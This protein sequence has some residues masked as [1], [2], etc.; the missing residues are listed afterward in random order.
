MSD[1]HAVTKTQSLL[2]RKHTD[3]TKLC[4]FRRIGYTSY[5]AKKNQNSV[6]N[7]KKIRERL[8][9]PQWNRI[10][11]THTFQ[12]YKHIVLGKNIFDT[13]PLFYS[14][15]Y[16]TIQKFLKAAYMKYIFHQLQLIL[17]SYVYYICTISYWSCPNL[18]Y[19]GSE[20]RMVSD[21]L[22]P[23]TQT[24]LLQDIHPMQVLIQL[25]TLHSKKNNQMFSSKLIQSS[26]W[27]CVLCSLP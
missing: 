26:L 25:P 3:K 2:S 10:L 27:M 5:L 16:P 1:I 11:R 8:L 12:K 7:N 13:I 17:K 20:N 24:L 9:F 15:Q 18:I 14:V 23:L 6:L 4:I 21:N 22:T 19:W